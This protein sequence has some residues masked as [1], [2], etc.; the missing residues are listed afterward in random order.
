MNI[1]TI[2]KPVGSLKILVHLN[3]N[4]K[5]TVTDLIKDA[6]LNQR[7]TYS[8]LS[9]LQ[10]QKLVSQN[11]AEGFPLYKYYKLTKKG[12]QIAE[13]LEEVDSILEK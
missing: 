3:R 13:H 4:E 11:V 8:A 1:G 5:A 7:T 2:E 9:N 6:G 10:N 12:R